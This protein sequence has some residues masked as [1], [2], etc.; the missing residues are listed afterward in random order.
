MSPNFEY[1][2]F[3]KRSSDVGSNRN[4]SGEKEPLLI[5]KA[6]YSSNSELRLSEVGSKL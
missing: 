3:S 4:R 6:R 5:S 1:I 2:T